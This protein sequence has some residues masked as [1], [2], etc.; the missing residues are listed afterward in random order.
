VFEQPDDTGG[1]KNV[2]GMNETPVAGARAA[3]PCATADI[4]SRQG[5]VAEASRKPRR[6]LLYTHYWTRAPVTLRRW[7]MMRTAWTGLH[8]Q[9][10]PSA[11]RHVGQSS[12][13]W[14]PVKSYRAFRR[15]DGRSRARCMDSVDES[16][17]EEGECPEPEAGGACDVQHDSRAS[18]PESG[19]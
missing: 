1:A 4:L 19:T 17:D 15:G 6:T 9:R 14:S 3:M 7:R 13:V 2:R 16:K 18:P 5:R 10:V 12:G 11:T 8:D